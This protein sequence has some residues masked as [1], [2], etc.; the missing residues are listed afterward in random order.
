MKRNAEKVDSEVQVELAMPSKQDILN[1]LSGRMTKDIADA[2]EH[3]E[4]HEIVGLIEM[5][6]MSI[7]MQVVSTI[8][9]KTPMMEH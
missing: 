2:L 8:K 3:L 7:G 1:A 4:V 9:S 5:I 6:K